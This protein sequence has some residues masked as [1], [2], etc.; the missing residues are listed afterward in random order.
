MAGR[1]FAIG[2]I[3]G[4]LQHLYTL[5]SSFP[6]LDEGDT[7][8]FLG[9]YL[10]RGAK[11]RQVIEFLRRYLPN[12]TRAR[13]VALRGNHE[14]AW[15]KVIAEGWP[16]FVLPFNNG[17]LATLRS[18]TGGPPPEPDEVFTK[19]EAKALMSGTFL[20]EDVV[21]WMKQLPY[22]SEDEH[23]IYVHAGIPKRDGRFPHPSEVEDKTPLL[24]IRTTEFF[25][26]YRGKRVVVGHTTT[27]TLPQDLSSYTPD[28]PTDLWAG[29]AVIAIDTGCGQGGFLTAIEFPSMTVY[30]SRP[31]QPKRL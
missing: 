15:L 21:S 13:L 6:P 11:S 31:G 26:K 14:D 28:D 30:E 20:P 12:E 8:V 7:L 23:A 18:F 4:E 3:H 24:W 1:T 2:D 22:F 27:D 16:G 25:E 19:E 9:D 5:L 29:E 10:D 17:C